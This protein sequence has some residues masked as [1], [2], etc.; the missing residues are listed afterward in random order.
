MS[1]I[2]IPKKI[3]RKI[4]FINLI[5]KLRYINTLLIFFYDLDQTWPKCGPPTYFCGPWTF[6][7]YEKKQHIDLLL[8]KIWSKAV[9][10]SIKRTKFFLLHR[11]CNFHDHFFEWCGPRWKIVFKFGSRSKKSGHPDLDSW[12][13]QIL[14]INFHIIPEV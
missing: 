10:K 9:N 14:S 13:A 6:L 7:C 5:D 4:N 1:N 8:P 12:A 2:R 11:N 3:T